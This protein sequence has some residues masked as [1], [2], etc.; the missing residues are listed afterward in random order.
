MKKIKITIIISVVFSVVSIGQTSKYR[1]TQKIK[2][3]GDN[4]WDCIRSDD[5]GSR[6]FVSHGTVVQVVNQKDGKLLGTIANCKGVHDIALAHDFQKGFISNGK[7]SSV[8][9]FDMKTL[10][11]L[12]NFKIPGVNPDI[13]LYD[14]FSKKVF[15]YNARSNDATVLDVVTNKILATIPFG[16]NPEFSVSDGKGKIYVNIEDKSEIKVI[17]AITLKVEQTWPLS[18][19]EEPT[20]LA[21]DNKTHRLFS[22]CAN[23]LMIVTDAESGKIITK[24]AIGDGCDGSVFDEEKKRIYCSNGEGTMTV[25]EE[26]D[27]N[28]FVVL[29]T[30]TTQKGARTLTINEKTHHIYMPTAEYGVAPAPTAE[31]PKPRP[32]IVPGSF[33]I[34]DIE[35]L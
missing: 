10:Q 34:L 11:T 6:L 12:T 21:L 25:I 3:E 28:T 30:V 17:N 5:E 16:G 27:A 33:V 2:I 4:G 1:I 15:V 9:V 35:T 31:H 13:M 7:D 18:P 22:A 14:K 23:K 26:K 8:T 19:G 29:E 32:K 20:G 24:L